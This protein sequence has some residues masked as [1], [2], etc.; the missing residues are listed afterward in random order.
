MTHSQKINALLAQGRVQDA[1]RLHS[2]AVD[3]VLPDDPDAPVDGNA[4]LDLLRGMVLL[5]GAGRNN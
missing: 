2:D 5:Q 4:F 3:D 1:A